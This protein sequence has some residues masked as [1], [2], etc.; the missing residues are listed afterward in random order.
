L[1]HQLGEVDALDELHDQDL[2][3]PELLGLVDAD[4]VRVAQARELRLTLEALHDAAVVEQVGADDLQ[5]HGSIEQAVFGLVDRAHAATPDRVGD[6]VA[7]VVS[8]LFGEARL[9]AGLVRG[10]PVRATPIDGRP[11]WVQR[12]DLT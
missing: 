5:H 4:D 3:E 10:T 12:F 1:L 2:R 11:E 8:E 9:L 7:R 6:A